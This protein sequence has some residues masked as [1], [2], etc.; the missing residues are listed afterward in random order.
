[1]RKDVIC[2][3]SEFFR[4]A[5]STRWLEGQEKV[6]RLPEVKLELFQVYIDWTYT[7]TLIF[8]AVVKLTTSNKPS[9]RGLVDMYLLGDV[10]DDVKLRN[11][12]MQLLSTHATT[13]QQPSNKTM[14]HIW[15]NTPTNSILRK[16][17]VDITILKLNRKCFAKS[18][19]ELPAEFTF[20]I[21]TRL[22]Q[23]TKTV[24][25]EELKEK[26]LSLEYLEP[27]SKGPVP[28]V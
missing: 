7:N 1:V 28:E 20:Q 10:L 25:M 3:K 11:K 8:G 21:A 27:E 18:A 6:V 23:Q 2:S 15:R 12:A 19:E 4:A 13:N 22:F 16:W 5:C 9:C 14:R 24:P 26:L 17:T